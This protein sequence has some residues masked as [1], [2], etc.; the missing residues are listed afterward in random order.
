MKTLPE[1]GQAQGFNPANNRDTLDLSIF[2]HHCKTSKQTN[3]HTNPKAQPGT[4]FAMLHTSYGAIYCLEEFPD[5]MVAI[6]SKPKY[7]LK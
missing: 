3:K 2:I 1:L 7:N 5:L 4:E 6:A